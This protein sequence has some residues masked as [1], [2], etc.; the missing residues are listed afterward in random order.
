M[1]ILSV[2]VLFFF[3]G[4]HSFAQEKHTVSGYISDENGEMLIGVNIYVPN[5]AYGAVSN[6]YGFYSL[7]LPKGSYSLIYSFIGFETYE[8]TI[9]LDREIKHSVTL[10]PETR[11]IQEVLITAVRKDK[12]VQEIM[13]GNVTLQ[14]KTIKK[15][16][17]L[18]GE[19]DIIKSI[20]LLPGVQTSVEGSSGFYVRGGNADQNLV[21]LDGATVYNPSHLF[22]FFSVF[23]GDAIKNVELYKG[24]IPAEYGGRLSSVLD[25]RMKEGN[26]QKIHGNAGIGLISSRLTVEGPVFKDRISF[27]LSAR[28]TYADLMLPFAKDTIAKESK[29]FFYDLNAKVNIKI[30]ENNRIFVSGYFGRDVNIF[31]DFFQMNFGNATGTLR[32]NHSYNGRIF[33]NLTLIYHGLQ[34]VIPYCRQR[35]EK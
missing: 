29:F 32:W 3:I 27:L 33:S 22:G 16:P 4:F 1:R 10:R 18:M 26:T 17:N 8:T 13:M 28:R 7:T 9:S 5:T 25:V 20:Q 11:E 34:M 24:G 15:I 14:A 19:T 2:V 35:T 21:L 31:A 6:T 12:N 30:N 23:N